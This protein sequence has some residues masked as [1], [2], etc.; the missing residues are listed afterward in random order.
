S[1]VLLLALVEERISEGDRGGHR[2]GHSQSVDAPVL[3]ENVRLE[4]SDVASTVVDGEEETTGELS[5]PWC[6][7]ERL[8][9]RP[10]QSGQ[11]G[12]PVEPGERTGHDIANPLVTLRRPESSC[13]QARAEFDSHVRLKPTQLHVAP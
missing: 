3:K 10:Y 11:V 4:S 2:I 6:R 8:V 9:Q 13:V 5:D 1:R 12:C 7:A